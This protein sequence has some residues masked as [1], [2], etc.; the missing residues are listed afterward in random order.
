MTHCEICGLIQWFWKMWT[1]SLDH[2]DCHSQCLWHHENVREDDGRIELESIQWLHE[3]CTW[4]H[5]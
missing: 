5:T 3:M 1:L 2:L 4:E